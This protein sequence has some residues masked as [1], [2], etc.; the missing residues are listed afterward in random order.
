MGFFSTKKIEV[1]T[2]TI[3]VDIETVRAKLI[4]MM[5]SKGT[6]TLKEDTKTRVVFVK[7]GS[8]ASSL[9]GSMLAGGYRPKSKWLYTFVLVPAQAGVNVAVTC[10]LLST[11]HYG[12]PNTQRVASG[13]TYAKTWL[14]ELRAECLN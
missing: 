6:V 14:D 1:P 8:E 9:I 3:N 4:L 7:E 10:E 11:N 2:A 5:L 12:V 13:G